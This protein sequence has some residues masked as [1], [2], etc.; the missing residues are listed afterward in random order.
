MIRLNTSEEAIEVANSIVNHPSVFKEISLGLST[1][2][3]GS[4]IENRDNV[5]LLNEPGDLIMY[6]KDGRDGVYQVHLALIFSSGSSGLGLIKESL[7]IMKEH[8][9]ASTIYGI[10]SP[11][12]KP[13]RVV[14]RSLGFNKMDEYFLLQETQEPLIKYVKEI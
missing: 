14:A 13:A 12:N 9:S 6:V 10:C 11:E 5:F 4:L 2:D 7:N 3:V 8:F 1:L